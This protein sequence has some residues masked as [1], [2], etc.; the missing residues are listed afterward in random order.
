MEGAPMQHMVVACGNLLG[1]Q[2]KIKI[3]FSKKL[4]AVCLG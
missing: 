3:M 4:A 2:L 1:R